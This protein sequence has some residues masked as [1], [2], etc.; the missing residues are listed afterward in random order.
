MTD[1]KK[2]FEFDEK[3]AQQLSLLFRTDELRKLRRQY[4][5]LLSLS[6]GEYVLDVGCGTG[7]NAMALA[8]HLHGNCTVIGVDASQPMLQIGERILPT[9][10]YADSIRLQTAEAHQ[11]PFPDDDFDAAMII[12]VLEYSKEPIRMLQETKR[13]LKPGGKIFV[14]DTD[15]DTIVWN[16]NL[17]ERTRQIVLGWSDHEADGWQGRKILEYMI[18]A[19]FQNV[20][21]RTFTI[22]ASSFDEE[23]YSYLMTRIIADYMIRSEKMAASE[24][25]E[26]IQDLKSKA[27]AGH[28]Y[29]SLNRYVFVG[30][31]ETEGT[32]SPRQRAIGTKE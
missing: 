19:G 27:E 26:W 1:E 28:F 13:V 10:A 16:S 9:F 4:F 24:V 7:A 12:Q 29:F 32:A 25:E 8:E 18:R 2:G 17:K 6:G 20:Q 14:A 5:D 30:Y 31:K 22:A 21:G 15:W 3:V 23:S 11:L